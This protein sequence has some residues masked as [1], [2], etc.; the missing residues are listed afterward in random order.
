MLFALPR[1]II[2]ICF[3]LFDLKVICYTTDCPV[4]LGRLWRRP[5]LR[6]TSPY[7]PSLKT[8][9]IETIRFSKIKRSAPQ[10][11]ARPMGYLPIDRAD[12]NQI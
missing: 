3:T 8:Q 10:G 7:R 11:N 5:T 6:K 2:D 1:K 4:K 12:Q 9:V